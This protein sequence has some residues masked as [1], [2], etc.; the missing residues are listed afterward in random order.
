MQEFSI[1][2]RH[3]GCFSE[4]TAG[5][6]KIIM[7]GVG[8]TLARKLHTIW[9]VRAPSENELDDFVAA[10]E[11]HFNVSEVSITDRIGSVAHITVTSDKE[12]S[13]GKRLKD[14]SCIQ[15]GQ[16]EIR[17][18]EEIWNFVAADERNMEKCIKAFK[19]VGEARLLH[20]K[21][22]SSMP[23]ENEELEVKLKKLLT[24]NQT[25]LLQSAIKSGYYDWPKKAKLQD[26]AK[27]HGK[28]YQAFQDALHRAESKVMKQLLAEMTA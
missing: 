4:V 23:G 22:F 13:L 1:S 9:F 12:I 27:K 7:K 15:L 5:F 28:S 10:L 2:I 24:E 17:N 6:P 21:R 8:W 11:K 20:T 16:S 14:I 3:K 19:S 26:L 18:G 25:R